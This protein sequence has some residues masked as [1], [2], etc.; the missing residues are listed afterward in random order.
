M[1]QRAL[2]LRSLLETDDDSLESI[3]NEDW[4]TLQI[5]HDLLQ[6]FWVLTLR[7][8]GQ[9][10]SGYNGAV[11]EVLPAI[12]VLIDHLEGARRKYSARKSKHIL[13]CINNAL[14]KLRKYFDLLDAS[15]AYAVSLVLNP[16]IK[17]C[18]LDEGWKTWK[19]EI[20]F[21]K[22]KGGFRTSGPLNIRIK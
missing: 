6:P 4:N 12:K 9:A 1:L 7:L 15:P 17:A 18:F 13:V 22:P 3:S 16:A 20:G 14:A 21:P 8:Q 10:V 11:W 2:K 19:R 5:L